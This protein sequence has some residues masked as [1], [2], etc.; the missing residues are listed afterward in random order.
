MRHVSVLGPTGAGK[1]V[2]YFM[3]TLLLTPGSKVVTD[4]KGTLF[5]LFSGVLK[6]I[7]GYK[8]LLIDIMNT[9][10]SLHYN[11]LVELKNESDARSWAEASC[12]MHNSSGKTEGIWKRGAI[13]CIEIILICL[14]RMKMPQY[15]NVTNLIYLVGK[16]G[17][18]EIG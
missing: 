4:V 12:G 14:M 3:N 9:E 1:S 6:H 8:I 7:M 10:R 18:Q 15:L 11:T 5:R 13:R 17:S 16:L 2:I